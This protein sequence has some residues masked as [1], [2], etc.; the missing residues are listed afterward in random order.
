M[1][2]LEINL[3]RSSPQVGLAD[4]VRWGDEDDLSN[5]K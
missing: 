4:P 5:A 1:T 2:V 3:R